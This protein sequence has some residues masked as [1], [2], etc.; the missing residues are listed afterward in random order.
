MFL[1]LTDEDGELVLVNVN[2]LEAIFQ[3][4]E[5]GQGW[6]FFASGKEILVK[7]SRDQI[8]ELLQKMDSEYS[9]VQELDD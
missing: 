2:T 9:P 7:E 1:Q 5:T 4:L 3:D 8:L 6:L